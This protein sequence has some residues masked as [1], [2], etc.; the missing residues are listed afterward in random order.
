MRGSI[1]LNQFYCFTLC[2]NLKGKA[3]DT[4]L[5]HILVL[6]GILPGGGPKLFPISKQIKL[7]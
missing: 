3:Q 7:Q 4:F 1:F 6:M 5:N 2:V